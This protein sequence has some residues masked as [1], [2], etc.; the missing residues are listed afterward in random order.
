MKRIKP[1][2]LVKT[3][4][5]SGKW[6]FV[7][8]GN[9]NNIHILKKI[10]EL[11]RKGETHSFYKIS[12]LEIEKIELD[13]VLVVLKSSKKHLK[14]KITFT[15][16]YSIQDKRWR[17]KV[18]PPGVLFAS[19][20][21]SKEW[22]LDYLEVPKEHDYEKFISKIES[23][24]LGISIYDD[25][26]ED[27]ILF[28]KKLRKSYDGI[29]SVGG[30]L[31]T[32]SPIH[33]I[34]HME[35]INHLFR[36]EAEGF[37]NEHL[38]FILNLKNG[39]FDKSIYD[40]LVGFFYTDERVFIL[41]DI[42][43]ENRREKI[44]LNQ[45]RK[46]PLKY[47]KNGIEVNLLRGCYRACTFCSHVH[48]KRLRKTS[49]RSFKKFLVG[50]LEKVKDNE[51]ESN[52]SLTLNLTDD[53][54]LNLKDYFFEVSDILKSHGLKIYGIQTSIDSLSKLTDDDYKKISELEIFSGEPL[55]WIGTDAFTRS[56][57]KRLGKGNPKSYPIRDVVEKCEKY[58]IKNY[59]YWIVF[60]SESSW[61]EFFEEFFM[62]WRFYKEYE[63]FGLITT[64][65]YLIPYPYT[66]SYI[67]AY[68][69]GEEIVVRDVLK[70]EFSLF[71]YPLVCRES[72][73]DEELEI[74]L[75]PEKS[76]KN[77][78]L[79]QRKRFRELFQEI[80]YRFKKSNYFMSF[81]KTKKEELI[82][83]IEEEARSLLFE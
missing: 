67:K 74:L 27:Y 56:R 77:Y 8:E 16:F 1:F 66:P 47:I 5:F 53:D 40:S 7:K 72:P 41:K 46:T 65:I 60:D 70:G 3:V 33:V 2:P 83:W 51:I 11:K 38:E 17:D 31:A 36:G 14:R 43:I 20:S 81:D 79:L 73:K 21:I 71:N 44:F 75:D 13:N 59:H 58:R 10:Y 61:E 69:K 48:G 37:L 18:L 9:I 42:Q 6:I 4:S 35:G 78:M 45:F 82:N 63:Y 49:L 57:I 29:V 54:I 12:R 25:F 76:I 19:N 15:Y 34:A 24:L 62:V 55:F 32:L 64:S 50:Y 80:Y 23:E 26:F 68:K 22:D 30:P 52:K 28:L 39:E